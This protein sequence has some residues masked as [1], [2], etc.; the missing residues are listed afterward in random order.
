MMTKQWRSDDKCPT[1]NGDKK[2]KKTLPETSSKWW[3]KHKLNGDIN[4][5]E[6]AYKNINEKCDEMLS[7]T[8]TKGDEH[9][10]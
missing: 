7:E 1:V 6:I 3:Q 8:V 9:S 4:G 2:T 10:D 5:G